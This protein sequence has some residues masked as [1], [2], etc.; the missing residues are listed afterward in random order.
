MEI[1]DEIVEKY[2]KNTELRAV[3]NGSCV[4]YDPKTGNTCAVGHCMENPK[5]IAYSR[6]SVFN[7]TN[8][9]GRLKP[10]YRGHILCFWQDIQTL[11]DTRLFWEEVGLTERGKRFVKDLKSIYENC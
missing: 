11:H 10:E 7:I 6:S 1:I 5:L 4:Y 8:F 2:N 9:E 3:T